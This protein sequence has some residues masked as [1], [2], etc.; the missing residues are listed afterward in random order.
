MSVSKKIINLV[1][2]FDD[3]HWRKPEN[4]LDYIEKIIEEI[5][6]VKIS[7]FCPPRLGGLGLSLDP[8]WCKRVRELINSNYIVLGVHGLEHTQ[9]EFGSLTK[10]QALKKLTQAEEEFAKAE[11]PFVKCFRGPHWGLNIQSI[12][13]LIEKGY[14]H[15]YNHKDKAYLDVDE[16]IGMIRHIYYDWNLK[17]QLPDNLSATTIV[18]HGHTHNVCENGI[19]ETFSRLA[20]LNKVAKTSDIITIVWK[21]IHEV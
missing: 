14:T 15:I 10:E 1:P 3:F 16:H 19:R 12:L 13:A 20:E 18:A 17:D 8:D 9:E 2:E 4:C 6:D 5:P 7:L 11:L 21:F